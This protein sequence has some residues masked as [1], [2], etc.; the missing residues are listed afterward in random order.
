MSNYVVVGLNSEKYALS[1]S[2]VQEIIKVQPLTDVPCNKPYVKGVIN[3]RGKIV[4]V[5]GLASRF[6]VA[7]AL[8]SSSDR[9]VI[10][11]SG[12]EDIGIWV[13]SVEQV[14]LFEEILPPT[15]SGIGATQSFLSGL[16]R[17]N[18]RLVSVLDLHS[19]LGL[20]GAVG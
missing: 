12:E 4:P 8:P 2:E 15:D 5:I 11:S 18:D 7:E 13:D 1:I 17:L 14:A 19:V 16:A 20:R 3:L 9:I 10:V 6:G